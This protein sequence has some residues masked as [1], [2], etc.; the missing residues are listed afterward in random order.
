[1]EQ[2]EI[3][4]EKNKAK[5]GKSV[6]KNFFAT[7]IALPYVIFAIIVIALI[8]F[9]IGFFSANLFS[10]ANN[11]VQSNAQSNNEL[12]QSIANKTIDFINRNFLSAQGL[13]AK[14]ASIEEIGSSLYLL[15][16]DI[17]EGTNKAQSVQV[18]VTS[19]GKNLVLG[20]I[21]DLSKDIPKQQEQTFKPSQTAKPDVLLFTMSFCPYGSQAEDNIFPVIKLLKEKIN[22][23]P[24]YVIYSNYGGYPAYCLDEQQKY[25]S[26]HGV[27]EL[28]QDIREL[29]VFNQ[30][31]EKYFEFVSAINKNCSL[32]NIESCWEEQAKALNLDVNSINDCFETQKI[33]LLEKEI[34]LNSKYNVRGSPTLLI[35]ESNYDGDRSSNGFLQAICSA[36]TEK[37]AECGQQLSSSTTTTTGS[38]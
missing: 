31:K 11:N 14:L 9:F 37:P 1:L 12:K 2:E 16:V 21:L 30:N 34:K 20:N 32:N 7:K 4:L 22:F 23:E 36:F 3:D 24:H 25:C 18:Y 35:N 28:K 27:N 15:N 5:E 26:L 6:K 33:D 19:D 17:Y 13:E 8:V 10:N 29:C 38:C